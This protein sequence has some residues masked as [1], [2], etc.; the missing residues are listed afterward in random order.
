M[1]SEQ[2]FRNSIKK[3][4][5]TERKKQGLTQ[6][7]LAKKINRT[8]SNIC[9]YEQGDRLP[10]CDVLY[11][12]ADIFDCSADYLLGRSTNRKM[13]CSNKLSECSDE[14]FSILVSKLE[15][16]GFNVSKLMSED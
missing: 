2:H 13:D 11:Q 1:I 7:E 9:G 4:I 6:S 5:A 12:L 16:V 10:P 3:R 14:K 8:T 15:K